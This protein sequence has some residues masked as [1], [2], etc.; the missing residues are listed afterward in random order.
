MSELDALAKR[1]RGMKCAESGTMCVVSKCSAEEERQPKVGCY[2]ED[3]ADTI[4][5]EA[6]R[7]GTKISDAPGGDDTTYIL[8][9]IGVLIVSFLPVIAFAFHHF[10]LEY[11]K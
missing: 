2:M 5:S 9:N 10:V 1:C 8:I 7:K 11:G 4:C 6:V 3:E